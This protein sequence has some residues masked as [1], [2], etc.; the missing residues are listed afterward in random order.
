[1]SISFASA[2]TVPQDCLLWSSVSTPEPP[3]N[4]ADLQ[5]LQIARLN[6]QAITL[7]QQG[8]YAS[9]RDTFVFALCQ[10]KN[11]CENKDDS[12]VDDADIVKCYSD[13]HALD[14]L[15]PASSLTGRRYDFH[16][17]SAA[18]A[19]P[20]PG[21]AE[22]QDMVLY[23]KAFLLTSD[24]PCETAATAAVL[25][26][27]T[28]LL[29]HTEAIATGVSLLYKKAK[30]FYQQVATLIAQEGFSQYSSTM[31]VVM[32]AVL[33]NLA[34]CHCTAFLD[35]ISAAS[36][37]QQLSNL[38]EWVMQDSVAMS[39]S[40]YEFFQTSLLFANMR[41]LECRVAAAA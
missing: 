33:H 2:A 31:A 30:K 4:S 15:K 1:M 22:P 3:L 7:L 38:L 40:D 36:C 39:L 32:A 34:H 27:N 6:S 37:Q 28:G 23:D 24:I 18:T 35:H 20:Q 5:L 12:I 25:L 17:S 19:C 8:E 16:T 11:I 10:L 9:A 26:F 21:I 13:L 29:H 41:I 14:V